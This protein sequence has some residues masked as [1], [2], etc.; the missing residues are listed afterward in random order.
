[1]FLAI[2]KKPN[3]ICFFLFVYLLPCVS[4]ATDNS[5]NRQ[6]TLFTFTGNYG[7]V[8]YLV[9]PQLRLL[10]RRNNFN[11]FLNNTGAGYTFTKDWQIW[12]GQTMSTRAQD[13]TIASNIEYRIWQQLLWSHDYSFGR[14]ISRTRLE[15][16]KSENFA[17]WA[18]RLRERVYFTKPIVNYIS[19]AVNNEIFINLQT[20][21]WITTNRWDQNRAYIGLAYSKS[22]MITYGAGYMSEIVFS[23]PTQYNNVL[24]IS[25]AVNLET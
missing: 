4:L 9:E 5:E 15:E 3:L 23:Q 12:L 19:L 25:M 8:V 16:R 22:K 14:A 6:W 24:L 11:Q 1:M 7:K 2:I 21:P 18:Y 10:T 17:N 13:A 20:A